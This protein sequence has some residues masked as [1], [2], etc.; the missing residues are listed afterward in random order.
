MNIALAE[1]IRSFRKQRSLTQEQLAEVLGVTVGAVYKWEAKLS[2][3]D[4]SL[5][6]E[7]ADFFDTSVDVLLGYEMKDNRQAAT[8]RRLKE[9][10]RSKDRAGILEAEKALKK[11]PN[12]FEI[13]YNSAIMYE[14]FGL[15]QED[16]GQLRRALELLEHS[17]L[18]LAQNSDPKI[19]EHT[20][21]GDM[22]EVYISLGEVDQA[23]ELLK[24]HNSG[25]IY[26]DLIGLTLASDCKRCDEAIPFLS[27]ALLKNVTSLLRTIIGYMNVFFE[28]NEYKDAQDMLLWAIDILGGLRETGK[29]SF[30]EK[31]NAVLYAF[32]AYTQIKM[33]S[34]DDAY[35]SLCHAKQMA[36]D[37]DAAP[38]YSVNAVR[39]ITY[40]EMASAHDNLGATAMEGV[41]KAIDSIKDNCLSALWKEVNEHEG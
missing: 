1:N 25:G 6:V 15:E 34:K 5:I 17:R 40:G 14:M 7:M 19:S 4:L 18:L 36:E 21:Y 12:S 20:I 30:F 10:R 2:V 41:Q 16:K 39:Y 8:V 35:R 31:V 23:V 37:F 26:N 29:R 27:E 28:R 38:D 3:P 13:V 33:G 32:L 24:K 22:A 9:Y 11:Y